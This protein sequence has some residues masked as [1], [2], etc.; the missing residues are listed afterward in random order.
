M[1]TFT[2]QLISATYDAILKTIDNDA[3]GAA[4]KQLT[5]GLGNVTP[6]Y[7]SNTQIGIGITPTQALHVSGNALITGSITINTD[8]TISGNL[9]WGSLTDTGENITITKFVDAADGITNN[10]NDT[11][12]PTTAAVKSFVDSSITDQDLDILGD[13]GS[14]SVDLD[15]QSLSVTGTTNQII[16]SALDQSISLSLPTT[17]HRNLLGDVTGNLVGNVTGGT[18]SGTTGTFSGNVDIDGTLDVDD[19]ISIES[20]AFG[21][22]EIGGSSGGYRFKSSCIR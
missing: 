15:S 11:T 14:G 1:A 17:I 18:I 21:R 8:A 12:I 10:D 4:A 20:N 19:V 16:T 9:S 22:I 2:G 3:I 7:V 6:L 13:S 5:D